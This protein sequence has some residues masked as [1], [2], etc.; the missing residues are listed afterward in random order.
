MVLGNVVPCCPT[1]NSDRR[2][3]PWHKFLNTSQRVRAARSPEE[4]QHQIQCI[5]AYMEAH[6]NDTPPSWEASLTTDELQLLED[7]DLLLAA[8]SDGALA[9]A[10]TVKKSHVVFDRPA[11]M[12]EQM[13]DLARSFLK[14][15]TV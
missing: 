3:T 12:F 13:V 8:I 14:T 15:N 11:E 10:G 7:F 2:D 9:R 4:I 5:S 6:G 1:C